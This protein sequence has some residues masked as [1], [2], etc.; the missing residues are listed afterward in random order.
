MCG[1]VEWGVVPYAQACAWQAELVARRKAGEIPDLLIFCQHP[2]VITLGRNA[3]RENLLLPE[4]ELARR[5]VEVHA[6]N[7]GGDVTFHGP[8][9]L[10]GYP[11]IDLSG[12]RKD[13]VAYVRA[14]EEVLIRTAREFDIEA[15]RK[16]AP[17][18]KRQF[19]TG[20]WVGEEKLAAIGVHISRW[21][22]SHGF[23]LNVTTDVSYFDLIVPCGISGK[24]VASLERLCEP[25]GILRLRSGH[26]GQ[27]GRWAGQKGTELMDQAKAAVVESFGEV[28]DRTMEIVEPDQWE[29]W[30]GAQP[31]A[32]S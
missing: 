30:L 11:I 29:A 22:T 10:V 25:S 28:F 13:V 23:A 14:L 5:G 9:Q 1:V 4:E 2:P 15:G 32:A 20:V 8:G 24:G 19:Y 17:R 7:R 26:A 12:W 21:V 3:R 27:G 18:Q 16:A 6:S 31:A